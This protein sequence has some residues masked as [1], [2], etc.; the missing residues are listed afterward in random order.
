MPRAKHYNKETGRWEYADS[1]I[2]I[3]GSIGGNGEAGFS[4]IANVRQTET[5][6][7]ITITDKSG[8]TFAT[9]KN[10]ER[11][12]AGKTP[13]KGIDY[14]TASDKQEIAQQAADLI[15]IP[16]L[17]T[18][19]TLKQTNMAADAK[20]V[21]DA[22]INAGKNLV[23]LSN[24]I[25]HSSSGNVGYRWQSVILHYKGEV[26]EDTYFNIRT[27]EPFIEG[28]T[29]I[30]S[31]DC[32][33]VP[34]DTQGKS[35]RFKITKGNLSTFFTLENGRMIVP[36]ISGSSTF[37][38]LFDDDASSNNRPTSSVVGDG[39]WLS[40]FCIEKGNFHVET[41]SKYPKL[42]DQQKKEIQELAYSYHAVGYGSNPTFHYDTNLIRND[43]ATNRCYNPGNKH[44]SFGLCC[45][46]FIEMIWMGRSVKDFTETD[47]DSYSN[48]ITKAFD[49]GYMFE[50]NDR[51]RIGGVGRRDDNGKLIEY[52]GF[53]NPNKDGVAF[54]NSYSINSYF[55][56]EI[57]DSHENRELFLNLNW[58]RPFMHANDVAQE[59]FRMGCE[60]PFEELDIGDLIFTAP[61]GEL[62]SE[63]STFFND[64]CWRKIGHVVMVCDK[65]SDGTLKLIDCSN[66]YND[67]RQAIY[68]SSTGY[69]DP[70]NDFYLGGSEYNFEVSKATEIIS[71]IVMCARHPAAWGKNNME[72]VEHI[73]FIPMCESTGYSTNQA[74]PFK[75]GMAITKGRWYVYN[76]ELGRALVDAS[77]S[78]SVKWKSCPSAW[79]ELSDKT[80]DT[81]FVLKEEYASNYDPVAKGH[82]YIAFK[83]NN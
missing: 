32:S 52:Y 65:A 78:S 12:T 36:F 45:N 18:D 81:T 80:K 76:N 31:F 39:I 13:A 47:K 16:E 43:F 56:Y 73:D 27:T 24:P 71:N 5:G 6:A 54:K 58:F 15:E 62:S 9:I 1:V 20:A 61:R 11:G 82:F 7:T 29:Y 74:I 38:L 10:G 28:E 23:D 83:S 2:E 41:K 30:L 70:N 77:A 33:G 79:V 67:Y 26:E 3:N 46:T 25:K 17:I 63:A 55:D 44:P 69:K 37:N 49:W 64:M 59:L 72:G 22:I 40:N 42:T 48:K 50:F 21:G 60:I 57:T 19:T 75:E 66:H 14:F 68:R 8:T 34:S 35:F 4:P 53:K 51:K